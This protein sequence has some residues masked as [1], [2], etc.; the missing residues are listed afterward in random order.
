M[1]KIIAII[2]CSIPINSRNQKII[3]SIKSYY[4]EYEIHVITWNREGLTLKEKG[5]FHAYYCIAP[6]ADAKA[7]I[8]GMFGYKKYIQKT[9]NKIHPDIIIASHWSN[10]ILVAGT[11]TKGQKL[12]YEN[13]DIP[14][15]GYIVR[16]TSQLLEKWA[17][18]KTDLIIHASRFFMPLYPKRIPQIILENKPAFA[19]NFSH[20]KPQHPLRISF[21]GRIRYKEI[22][23]NLVDALKND[24]RYK[25][26]FHGS[27]EDFSFMQKYCKNVENVTFT[28]EYKYEDV[29]KLYHQSD[30]IWAAYPNKD[31]NVVY[32]ISNK[33]HESSYVGIPCVYSDHTKLAD[34]VEEKEIGLVVNP[35]DTNKIKALFSK[36]YDNKI[37]LETIKKNMI[38]F[39]KEETTWETDF[40]EFKT[41][42]E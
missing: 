34:F 9:F 35:Y 21:I 16:K 38:K 42:L 31:Y 27:G 36:I 20:K 12:I 10:L 5:N 25:L 11:K 18:R 33:F 4:P 39:H 32:A 3:N 6:Y 8:S 17:L 23:I 7:K 30:I 22:L 2:D 14:T 24:N 13:L 15:G 28:G 41:F 29:V 19:P 26:Y 40:Q 1:K 37:D